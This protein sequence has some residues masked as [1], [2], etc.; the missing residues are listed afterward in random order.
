MDNKVVVAGH[1][2]TILEK[3]ESHSGAYI[4][5]THGFNEVTP[6]VVWRYYPER[7]EFLSGNYCETLKGALNMFDDR[8]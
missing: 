1:E 6:Y 5:L 8:N 7:N 3:K 2:V 4:V